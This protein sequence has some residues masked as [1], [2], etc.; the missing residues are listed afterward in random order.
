MSL[1]EKLAIGIVL[2]LCASVRA[3]PLDLAARATNEFGLDL[4]RQ[5]AT[6]DKNLCL[7]PYSIEN[8][9]AMTFA[10]AEGDTRTEMAHV[11]HFP[12]QGEAIHSSYQA[13]RT[14][15]SDMSKK[16]EQIAAES[17]RSGGPSEPIRLSIANR[18]FVQRGYDLRDVFRQ[19]IEQ[20]YI[21]PMEQ[22]DF[23][24]KPDFAREHINKWVAEQTL[25][26]IR[27]LIPPGGTTK[28]TRLVLANAIYVKAPWQSEFNDAVT[29]PKPFHI[30]GASTV[31]VPTM[32]QRAQF[33]YAKR[34]GYSAVALP[35]TGG[36]LQFLILLPDAPG[37]LKSLETKLNAD[38]LAQFA[39]LDR[40]E[41]D[42]SLPRFKLEPATILLSEKLKALGM[43]TAFDDPVG[44]ANFDRMAART[45][46]DYLVISEV[47]HKTFIAVDEKGTEAAAATAV[48][49]LAASA[50]Q[51][52][53]QPVEVKVDHPFFYAIQ[54]ISTGTCLFTG[55]VTD[56]R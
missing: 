53:P 14:A 12:E 6:E 52:K 33:R 19:V 13:L 23:R 45:A 27:D 35:Y 20:F 50:M 25:E 3:A 44:T 54:H 41:V 36:D 4:Y 5:L 10:G 15:L 28:N 34:D 7:S 42:L 39:R 8:A 47:F 38:E 32:N 17:K 40:R 16:T 2:I 43:K 56:P 46:N 1:L 21:A 55:R 22:L 24:R 26:R 49:M 51:P 9:L 37:D 30:R 18:L 11:L 29:K 31:D 48:A